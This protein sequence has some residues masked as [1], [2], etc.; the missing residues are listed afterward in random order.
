MSGAICKREHNDQRLEP[1]SLLIYI[2]LA[3]LFVGLVFPLIC[4]DSLFWVFRLT[5]P[6]SSAVLRRASLSV[7]P[8]FLSALAV[9]TSRSKWILYLCGLKATWFAINCYL[10]CVCYGQ[11]GWLA[12]WLFM[13]FDT[14]TL[15]IL[16]FYWFRLLTVPSNKLIWMHICIFG[17][18]TL[19]LVIDYRIVTPYIAKFGFI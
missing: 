1:V 8:F 11:A 10:L 15:P 4:R 19:L 5:Y 18:I 16:F 12:R 6:I 14:C 13:F 9:F 7:L 2:W 3:G 17:I